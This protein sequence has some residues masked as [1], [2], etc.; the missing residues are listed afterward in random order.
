MANKAIVPFLLDEVIPNHDE[1]TY[2]FPI[3]FLLFDNEPPTVDRSVGSI[4][5][6]AQHSGPAGLRQ[7]ITDEV[8]RQAA[9]FEY[10]IDSAD[11]TIPK[12]QKGS[13]GGE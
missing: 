6:S 10:D 8:L 12:F 1:F 5:V 2:Q 9:A 7:K 3:N 13:D 4:R 11:I